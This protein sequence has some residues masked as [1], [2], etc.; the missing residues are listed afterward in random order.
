MNGPKNF[1]AGF[2]S[3]LPGGSLSGSPERFM[4]INAL[5]RPISDRFSGE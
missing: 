3:G 5:G 2:D 1:F 4:E